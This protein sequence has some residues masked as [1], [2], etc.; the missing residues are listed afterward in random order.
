MTS[1]LTYSGFCALVRKLKEQLAEEAVFLDG[2]PAQVSEF[3]GTNALTELLRSQ[4][5]VLA[6]AAFG[7]HWPDVN[8]FLYEWRP[9]FEIVTDATTPRAATYTINS[10]DDYFAY[11]KEQLSFQPEPA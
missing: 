7:E 5:E 1:H 9:G 10:I 2:L 4:C 11:A 8:W 3:L 6:S